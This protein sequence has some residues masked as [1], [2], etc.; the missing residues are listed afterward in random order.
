ME[1][2]NNHRQ[3]IK[4][5]YGI[6][7]TPRKAGYVK[8]Q[9]GR[10]RS[11]VF[12]PVHCFAREDFE[13]YFTYKTLNERNLMMSA[14]SF[15]RK[16][17]ATEDTIVNVFA[18]TIELSNPFP[19]TMPTK[20]IWELIEKSISKSVP[21]PTYIERA[22]NL[23]LVYILD[24]PFCM[25]FQKK[26]RRKDAVR[27]L[28][29]IKQN[30]CEEINKAT[31]GYLNAHIDRLARYVR[32]PNSVEQHFLMFRKKKGKGYDYHLTSSDTVSI[33]RNPDGKIWK[34]KELSDAAFHFSRPE[35]YD[36]WKRR[37]LHPAP[38]PKISISPRTG[39]RAR[40]NERKMR[41]LEDLTLN[42][43][44]KINPLTDEHAKDYCRELTCF[45]YQNF[46]LSAGYSLD[47][48]IKMVKELNQSF[49][50][51]LHLMEALMTA[52]PKKEYNLPYEYI[53][54]T[55]KVTEEEKKQLDLYDKKE[56][57]RA[58][59]R[60]RRSAAYRKKLE[61]GSTR[62]QLKEKAVLLAAKL[63]AAGKTV[64]EIAVEM[65]VC[66]RSVYNYLRVVPT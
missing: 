6:G 5:F 52:H 35:W 15:E 10:N 47:D 4:D 26:S 33:W 61:L 13:K 14:C 17:K 56:Y 18:L 49:Y 29:S 2:W 41:L 1:L 11:G 59:A 27:W 20:K 19:E 42:R 9:C 34:I 21:E 36:D 23:R 22:K 32:V 62:M 48:V 38:E 28:Q 60:E 16:K 37:Q 39:L 55:L 44:L 40:I 63:K 43:T 58:Y 31:D 51:P 64:L 57:D 30:I 54:K 65:K 3:Y 8:L 7:R 25:R 12:V 50:E 45:M 66:I 24:E 46:A 53:F